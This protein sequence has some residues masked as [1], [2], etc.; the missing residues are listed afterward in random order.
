MPLVV[1][2]LLD[3]DEDEDEEEDPVDESPL[4]EL[5]EELELSPKKARKRAMVI[6]RPALEE[7]E[8]PLED[9]EDEDEDELLELLDPALLRAELRLPRLLREPRRERGPREP[10]APR[11]P[12]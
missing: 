6:P 3:D 10:F 11:R 4:S 5:D 12:R 1:V 9:E 2:S 8:V 7:L